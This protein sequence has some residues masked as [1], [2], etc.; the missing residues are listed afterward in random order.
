MNKMEDVKRYEK[1]NKKAEC[2][3]YQ[4][5]EEEMIERGYK[6]RNVMNTELQIDEQ[7]KNLLPP[8]SP[9]EFSKLEELIINDGCTESIKVWKDKVTNITYIID[10][11]NRYQICTK[12]NIPF[13]VE[14]KG[15]NNKFEVI[16]WIINFQF[17]RRNLTPEERHYLTGLQYENE[18]TK[19]QWR[20][21]QH[22]KN[23]ATVVSSTATL[24]KDPIEEGKFQAITT[25]ERIAKQHGVSEKLIR[26]N[27]KYA[28]VVNEIA[29]LVGVEAKNKILTGEKKISKED[30]IELGKQIK[31]GDIDKDWL[32]EQF[33][34]SPEKKVKITRKEDT[35][36]KI[37]R[38]KKEP[39]KLVETLTPS[40]SIPESTSTLKPK[41]K[42]CDKC[43]EDKLLDDFYIGHDKCKI[44]EQ[45]TEE[46]KNKKEIDNNINAI[47]EDVKT[48]KTI[49]DFCDIDGEIEIFEI[50]CEEL[51]EQLNIKLFT[52]FDLV[53]KMDSEQIDL[54]ISVLNE[55]IEKINNIKLKLKG[56]F[57]YEQN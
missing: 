50:I 41:T 15:F 38:P 17:G 20:G 2:I 33:I 26:D 9:E 5:T 43:R 8:L 14:S 51:I 29:E 52:T 42:H 35:E 39:V 10:G 23:E 4:L 28:N 57:D 6:E 12:H 31:S 13:K 32:K 53:K 19:S 49:Y 30:V 47:I 18:K 3:S 1:L 22:T 7:F 44:C 16:D 25:A 56:E 37:G 55:H 40:T 46:R 36:K 54:T 27:G 45:I 21:N 34:E 24:Q 11:H 48:S